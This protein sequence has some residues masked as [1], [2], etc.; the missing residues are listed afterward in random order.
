MS[1]SIVI[2]VTRLTTLKTALRSVAAQTYDEWRVILVAHPDDD[3]DVISNPEL[4]KYCVSSEVLSSLADNEV[5]GKFYIEW[6]P[7]R[8]KHPEWAE[9]RNYVRR[10]LEGTYVAFLDDDDIWFPDHLQNCISAYEGAST[11]G[12]IEGRR[13]VVTSFYKIKASVRGYY[14]SVINVA[15]KDTGSE[16]AAFKKAQKQMYEDHQPHSG[17]E[18]Y[19]SLMRILNPDTVCASCLFLSGDDFYE[20]PFPEAFRLDGRALP[21]EDLRFVQQLLLANYA[22]IWIKSPPTAANMNYWGKN[23]VPSGEPDDIIRLGHVPHILKDVR[24]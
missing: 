1:V 15:G 10:E 14:E 3:A 4:G 11:I 12:Q 16:E 18:S 13:F 17:E 7:K 8:K 22:P 6:M 21:G 19:L 9:S 24:K 2:P 5:P 20:Y 23:Y